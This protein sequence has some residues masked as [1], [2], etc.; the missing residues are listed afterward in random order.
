MNTKDLLAN[1]PQ[2]QPVSMHIVNRSDAR[3]GETTGM[4]QTLTRQASLRGSALPSIGFDGLLNTGIYTKEDA[5]KELWFRESSL[6]VRAGLY[7]KSLGCSPSFQ[8]EAGCADVLAY[9]EANGLSSQVDW[10]GVGLD[11]LRHSNTD[12]LGEC[13]D[14]LASRYVALE[15][16]LERSL[17]GSELEAQKSQLEEIFER[18]KQNLTGGYIQR[19]G[20][21]LCFSQEDRDHLEA[22]FKGLI[23]GRIEVYRKVQENLTVNLSGKDQWLL[24]CDKYMASQLRQASDS[25][26]SSASAGGI[27]LNDLCWAGKIGADYQTFYSHVS[28]G[29]GGKEE[30]IA[31]DVAMAEMKVE[32]LIQRG[33]LSG[34]M[35]KL[36]SSSRQA[37]QQ[38]LLD[39]SDQRREAWRATSLPTAGV[40][41]DADRNRFQEVFGTVLDVF[42]QNGGDALAAVRKG[43]DFILRTARDTGVRYHY[44]D[45]D[46]SWYEKDVGKWKSFLADLGSGAALGMDIKA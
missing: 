7:D 10:D 23:A 4:G 32:T 3:L 43:V 28:H 30:I 41:K 5:V 38:Q 45:Y 15:K 37:R 39:V 42:A 27:T 14:Y 16:Q 25:I 44:E 36:L 35:E 29:R 2:L 9:V 13:I 19:L 31:L 26:S 17:S 8:Q 22:G 40:V 33:V 46:S 18:G 20:D 6:L 34:H 11:F 24:N 21:A 1:A 12:N